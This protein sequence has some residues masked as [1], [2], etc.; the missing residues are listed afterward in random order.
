MPLIPRLAI[1]ALVFLLAALPA[2]AD[3]PDASQPPRTSGPLFGIALP[4]EDNGPARR[5]EATGQSCS[6][7]YELLPADTDPDLDY[8]AYWFQMEI[9]PGTGMCAQHLMFEFDAPSDGSIVSAVPNKGGRIRS[10]SITTTELIVD[11]G[12]SALVPGTIAQ[13]VA[14]ARGRTTVNIDE[15]HYRYVWRG[16]SRDKVMIA[17]GIQLSSRRL[18]PEL[19]TTWSEGSGF[20]MGSCRPMVVR[21]GPG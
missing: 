21:V 1:G 14:P 7:S 19:I 9:D 8:W 10:R 5:G 20:G 3:D 18:P 12:G 4:C 17:V 15:R 6:W 16:N 13:D 2:A 11:G